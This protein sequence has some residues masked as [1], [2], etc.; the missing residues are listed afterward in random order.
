MKSLYR[1][2][3]LQRFDHLRT[4]PPQASGLE[5]EKARLFFYMHIYFVGFEARRCYSQLD[6]LFVAL[7][8][9]SRNNG[10]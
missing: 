5:K 9:R 2:I 7:P 10:R 3:E 6:C 1:H 4:F 8:Q